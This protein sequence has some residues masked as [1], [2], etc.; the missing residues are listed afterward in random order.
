MSRVPFLY[1]PAKG[2]SQ[3]SA[4]PACAV[5]PVLRIK[6]YKARIAPWRWFDMPE[7]K[8][9]S[10]GLISYFVLVAMDFPAPVGSESV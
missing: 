4:I 9:A 7:K 10:C 2:K 6:P 1:M 3:V 5:P 8:A